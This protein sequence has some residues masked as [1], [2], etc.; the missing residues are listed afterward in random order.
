MHMIRL[1]LL[2]V[3]SHPDESQ[4][5]P[6]KNV[7]QYLQEGGESRPKCI[8]RCRSATP[9]EFT[10]ILPLR[11]QQQ[12]VWV[13]VRHSEY[14]D[15]HRS[16]LG[17]CRF[18]SRRRTRLL[19]NSSQPLVLVIANHVPSRPSEDAKFHGHGAY[20]TQKHD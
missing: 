18:S 5:G 2:K 19:H 17:P 13:G 1:K 12:Y 20:P 8:K 10:P 9:G 14:R 15:Q 7:E 3:L 11:E 6:R 4:T 16:Q